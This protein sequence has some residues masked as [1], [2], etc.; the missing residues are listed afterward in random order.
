LVL[1]VVI[2]L[3]ALGSL[4]GRVAKLFVGS[5][6]W[7]VMVPMW[8]AGLLALFKVLGLLLPADL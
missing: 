4:Y 8:A 5:S 3:A 6:R 2:A 1:A 7:M